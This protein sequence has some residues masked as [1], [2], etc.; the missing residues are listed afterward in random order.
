[1]LMFEILSKKVV[2]GVMY[3]YVKERITGQYEWYKVDGV[4]YHTYEGIGTDDYCEYAGC[5][6]PAS[7]SIHAIKTVK[8]ERLT[9]TLVIKEIQLLMTNNGNLN[10][11]IQSLPD[12]KD[13]AARLQR[14]IDLANAI[15]K[16]AKRLQEAN[17]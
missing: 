17:K 4:P 9:T 7:H 14:I 13:V 3:V 12:G 10:V 5:G 1:M 8:S 15:A 16:N 2:N 6:L 11:E